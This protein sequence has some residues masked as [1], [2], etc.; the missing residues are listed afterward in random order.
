MTPH[1]RMFLEKFNLPCQLLP[2]VYF[3]LSR[4]IHFRKEDYQ[5]KTFKTKA[6]QKA[7]FGNN[8]NIV[9]QRT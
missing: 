6:K 4:N 2:P 7:F 8:V 9:A 1:F 3:Q 5:N